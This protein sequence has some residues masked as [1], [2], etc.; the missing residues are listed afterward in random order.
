MMIGPGN[1]SFGATGF[2]VPEKRLAEHV[3]RPGKIRAYG[4]VAEGRA[5]IEFC[6]ALRRPR[7]ESK[8]A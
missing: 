2:S 5:W 6:D 8:S 7:D 4:K 1:V 3:N